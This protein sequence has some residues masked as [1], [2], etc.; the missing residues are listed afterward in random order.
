MASLGSGRGGRPWQR[1]RKRIFERDKYL[2]Q[3]CLDKGLY[4]SVSLHGDGFGVC[5]HIVAKA[6]GGPDDDSNLQTL[7]QSCSNRKTLS[8]SLRGRGG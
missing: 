6:F 4:Q 1:T 3:T 2:C 8:E 7:C 5:D